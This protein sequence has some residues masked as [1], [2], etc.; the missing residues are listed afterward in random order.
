M[1]IKAVRT[2]VFQEKDNL[3]NFI[4]NQISSLEEGDIVAVTSKIVA[5][6][7]GRIGK[8]KD[9]EKLIRQNSKKIIKTPWAL[10]TLA[11][12]EWC[13][14]A[15]VDESNAK[16]KIIL[17]PKNPFK[18][19]EEIQKN[20]KKRF[21]IKNL[22]I[23]ITDTKSMPLRVGTTGKPI[24]Y[25]GF[26][27]LR[28]YVGKKDLFGRKSR[29]T[30]SNIADALA[31]IAV[32]VMGEGNEQ[33]PIAVI[34]KAPVEFTNKKISQKTNL[35]ISPQTDIYSKIYKKMPG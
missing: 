16:N 23:I 6:S 10:L 11:G 3:I 4:N 34:K 19:A 8:I 2:P 15:G 35:A 7:Q 25:A 33:T 14:N 12:G 1:H 28:S 29:F 32:L 5:L 20:L 31:A 24:A 21:S 13:I 9:K 17:L 26:K 30:Q 18:V 22:G 27:P